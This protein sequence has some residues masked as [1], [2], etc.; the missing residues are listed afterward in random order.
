MCAIVFG[1]FMAKRSDALKKAQKAYYEAH[2]EQCCAYSRA[3]YQAHK[4]DPEFMARVK[5]CKRRYREKLRTPEHQA[6]IDVRRARA[7]ERR[8]KNRKVARERYWRIKE[9]LAQKG[10]TPYAEVGRSYY[11]KHGKECR[12]RANKYY[13]EHKEAIL[14]KA[15]AR[16]EAIK[17]QKEKQTC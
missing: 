13:H 8:E 3:Y 14:L 5:E 2:K 10:T 1:G 9:E 6:Q 16:R 4:Y 12:A 15:K 11:L 7:E 17:Q